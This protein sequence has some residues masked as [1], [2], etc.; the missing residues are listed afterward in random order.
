MPLFELSTGQ[1]AHVTSLAAEIILS[2]TFSSDLYFFHS[3]NV[4]LRGENFIDKNVDSFD[5]LAKAH[6]AQ[7]KK[8]HQRGN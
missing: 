5:K 1:M 3:A 2:G 4:E 7:I 6:V 8:H